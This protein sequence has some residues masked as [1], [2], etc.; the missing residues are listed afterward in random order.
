[1]SRL[2][3][4]PALIW[5]HRWLGLI[6]TPVFLV[7]ILSGAVLSFRPVVAD[8]AARIAAA[9]TA[10]PAALAA[11]TARLEAAGRVDAITLAEGGQAVDVAAGDRAL[12]GRWQIATG[13]RLSAPSSPVDVFRTAETLHKS[14]LLG[15]APLVEAAAFAMLAIVVFGPLLTWIRFRNTLLGWHMIIGWCLLPLVLMP[16]LTAGL[17]ITGIGAGVRVPLP[18]AESPV[19]IAAALGTAGDSLDLAHL[20]SARRF[21]GGTV[22]VQIA[23]PAA[24]AAVV[25][26]KSVTRLEG[27]PGLAKQIHEGTWAGAWS[28]LLNF[29][30]SLALLGLTATGFLSWFRRWRRDRAAGP[31]AA[32]GSVLVVHASQT[33]TAA[34]LAAA[35]AAALEAGGHTVAVAPLG[36]LTP[37]G[38]AGFPRVV[39]IAAT[40]GEGDVPDGARGFLKALAAGTAGGGTPLAGV[41][42]AVLALGDRSYQHFCGGG[43]TL[44]TALLAAGAREATPMLCADGDPE[45]IWRQWMTQLGRDPGLAGDAGAAPALSGPPVALRLADRWR[46]DDPACPG[47]QETWAVVLESETRLA[48][49]PGDL[50]RITPP[51]GGAPRSYSIGSTDSGAP[52]RL[53]LTVRLHTRT[54]AAGNTVSGQVSGALTRTLPPGGRVEA[55]IAPHPGFNPPDDPNRPVILIGAGSGIAPFPGFLEERRAARPAGPVWLVFGNRHRDGDFLWRDAIRAALADG[56]LTRLDT[57][58]S[59]DADDAAHVGD[60]LRAAGA[61]LAHWMLHRNAVLYI[62]GRRA[63]VDSVQAALADVL[64]RFGALTESAAQTTLDRWTGEG[65]VRI[66]AFD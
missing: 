41:H 53:V 8:S 13:N 38:L 51:G 58:F 21:R 20:V 55:T 39:L 23:G 50:V 47:T 49:R 31:K 16:P 22:L 45:G 54:D 10:D 63:F 36:R 14:L 59:R 6:L 2:R 32:G 27:G 43:H 3:I 29:A 19:S 52:Q 18:R 4:R 60:R 40:T 61:D 37:A 9:G 35:T 7:I 62:C 48:F 26:D 28:G 11:L 42:L 57:A 15:L 66:D 5:L 65:R 44:R 24:T 12:A 64:V 33:G 56:T 17:M 25:T 30:A 34:R 46:L 1:M